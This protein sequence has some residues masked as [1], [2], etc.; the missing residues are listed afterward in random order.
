[1]NPRATAL[2]ALTLLAPA[3]TAGELLLPRELTVEDP[4]VAALA[5]R[6]ADSISA[7]EHGDPS[8]RG[9]LLATRAL[10][11]VQGRDGAPLAAEA[12]APLWSAACAGLPAV[13]DLRPDATPLH[14]DAALLPERDQAAL[15]WLAHAWVTGEPSDLERACT[16]G[17]S[18]ACVEGDAPTPE[19]QERACLDGWA[20]G[21]LAWSSRATPPAAAALNRLACD[22][23]A[24]DGCVNLALA[25]RDGAGVPRELATADALLDQACGQGD[26]R[27]CFERGLPHERSGPELDLGLAL[28]DYL[29]GCALG[30]GASC[31]RAGALHLEVRLVDEAVNNWVAGCRAGSRQACLDL[32]RVV[33]P[34]RGAR[35]AAELHAEALARACLA[36]EL[37][38]CAPTAQRY[39]HGLWIRSD[40]ERAAELFTFACTQGASRACAPALRLT[41]DRPKREALL[42]TLT[43]VC[44]DGEQA[45]CRLVERAST[46]DPTDD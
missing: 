42:L 28:D 8:V 26:G 36:G 15:A 21:C 5:Q 7:L 16:A 13:C 38:L 46:L 41:D 27:A 44:D 24:L 40:R 19:Q 6:V 20:K 32:A 11:L 3:A 17:A 34:Q 22:F 31:Q 35:P 12:V 23:G 30:H 25:Y 33:D 45:A 10:V 39:Q 2:L 37:S 43:L 29:R 1:M 18:R 14:L 4:D 9:E